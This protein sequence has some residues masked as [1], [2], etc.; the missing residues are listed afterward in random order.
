L[1]GRQRDQD[2]ITNRAPETKMAQESEYT[3]LSLN[4]AEGWIIETATRE[5]AVKSSLR[6]MPI[7]T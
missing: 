6:G 3:F 1:D 5:G 7:D 2:V 4:D